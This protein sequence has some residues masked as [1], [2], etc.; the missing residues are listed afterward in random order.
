MTADG[1]RNSLA[2]ARPRRSFSLRTYLVLLVLLVLLPNAVLLIH[3]AFIQHRQAAVAAERRALE[4]ARTAALKQMRLIAHSRALLLSVSELL[5]QA[6]RLQHCNRHLAVLHAA[7]PYYTNLGVINA[8]GRIIC[9]AIPLAHSITVAD[10]TY[11]RRAWS[12]Q[13]LVVGN[14]QIGRV[15]GKPTLV[16]ALPAAGPR[17]HYVVF[18]AV[19]LA[20]VR[21]MIAGLPRGHGTTITVADGHGTVLAQD[22]D[23]QARIGKPFPNLALMR[24]I[25]HAGSPGTAELAGPDHVMRLYGFAPLA[26]G[27]GSHLYV[28]AGIARTVAFAAANAAFARNLILFSLV[29]LVALAAAWIGSNLLIL[30]R[31]TAISHA[32]H[33]LSQGNFAARTGIGHDENEFGKIASALDD[34]AEKLQHHQRDIDTQN[35]LLGQVNRALLTLGACNRTLVRALDEQSLLEEMCRVIVDTGGYRLAWVGYAEHDARKHIRM[36]AHAGFNQGYLESLGLTW[37][38]NERGR[39]PAGTAI[40]TGAP[41]LVHDVTTDARFGIWRQDAVSRGYRACIALPLRI[42]G[43]TT[44][45]L[46]IY[47]QE[48]GAFST[49]EVQLLSELAGDVEFGI[50]ALRTRAHSE[51]A[52]EALWQMAYYDQVTGLPNHTRLSEF[53]QQLLGEAP[54]NGHPFSLM[55]LDIDRFRDINDAIGTRHANR[56]LHRIAQRIRNA[57]PEEEMVVRMRGDEFAVLLPEHDRDYAIETSRRVMEIMREPFAD[58]DLSLD[59][60]LSIGITQFPRDGTEAEQLLRRADLAVRRAKQSENGYALYEPELDDDSPRRL[61]LASDL[62][63]AIDTGELI[64]YYQP[65][66]D[67]HTGELA[68]VEALARWTSRKYGNISPD[69]FISLAEQTGLIRP[70]TYSA[71]ETALR[72]QRAWALTGMNIPVAVNLSARNLHDSTLL[73]RITQLMQAYDVPPGN[74]ELEITETAIMADPGG[75]LEILNRLSSMGI[76]LSI[77]DFGTGYSSLGYLGKLP[78]NAIKIDKS[79]VIDMISNADSEMIVHSTIG[80]A[81]DLRLHVV[82]E[83]I[84]STAVWRRLHALGCDTAQGYLVARPMPARDLETWLQEQMKTGVWEGRIDAA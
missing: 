77:D 29:A 69:E 5:L 73:D 19:D 12:G 24:R 74:L 72:Q 44:G 58:G 45:V 39:G 63:Q 40:R 49:R 2:L 31:A 36:V 22:P 34:M 46:L 55:I 57:I 16:F 32:A 18:A 48:I 17:E 30:R 66:I 68:G 15:T 1:K 75:A 20:W 13:G 27:S 53:L 50:E 43:Q 38:D 82:A 79:F 81:H 84:E 21:H 11:F 59:V 14:Y 65:K 61:A 6:S 51:K 9:S 8:H 70:L 78:V 35:Q 64:Q 67:M 62:R 10:R 60:Q 56:L 37:E 41:C 42:S 3:T 23:A 26:I 7:A 80:L 83:G 71:I 47:A 33:L 76:Q 52:H 25:R 28:I 4:L 54:G